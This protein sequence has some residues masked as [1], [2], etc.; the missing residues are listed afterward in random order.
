V[1]RLI[2]LLIA[3][4]SIFLQTIVASL[5]NE[6]YDLE[7]FFLSS[8]ANIS[9]PNYLI[10]LWF[11]FNYRSLGT[12]DPRCTLWSTGFFSLLSDPKGLVLP[13]LK[14]YT[15]FSKTALLNAT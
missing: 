6:D 15:A 14:Y 4:K 8:Y 1:H 13:D 9:L 12:D 3:Y 2:H 7:S 5:D 11:M 10:S